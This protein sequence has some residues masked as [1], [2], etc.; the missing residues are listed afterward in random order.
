MGTRNMQGDNVSHPAHDGL[1]SEGARW[2]LSHSPELLLA[3]A[4]DILLLMFTHINPPLIQCTAVNDLD[5]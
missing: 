2:I 3:S 4:N 1:P 5:K